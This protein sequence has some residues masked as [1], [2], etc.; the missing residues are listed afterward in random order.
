MA[1]AYCDAAVC[2]VDS[3]L[4]T[5][6]NPIPTETMNEKS[7][8]T[9]IGFKAN[10]FKF[11]KAV[12]L[13]P[14]PTGFVEVRGPNE[15][16]KSTILDAIDA[17]LRGRKSNPDEPIRHGA[18]RADVELDLGEY[19][20]RKRW[21]DPKNPGKNSLVVENGTGAAFSS[22]QGILDALYANTADP[23]AF[24][25]LSDAEKVKMVLPMVDLGID[26]AESA[27]SEKNSFDE[28]Q[29][30]NREVTSLTGAVAELEKKVGPVPLEATLS[31]G[32]L[33]K[34]L[35]SAIEQNA[36]KEKAQQ[37]YDNCIA[38]YAEQ[39]TTVAALEAKLADAKTELTRILA[40]GKLVRAELDAMPEPPSVEKV[41]TQIEAAETNQ[42]ATAAV[43]TLE[44]K[45]TE[46]AAKKAESEK[47]DAI[48]E[49]IRTARKDALAAAKF[50]VD[51]M[52]YDLENNRL[53]LKNIP[54][55]QAS[56]AERL[57]AATRLSMAGKPRIRVMFIRN[58]N[59]LD[60]KHKKI[61]LDLAVAEGWQVWIEIVDEKQDGPGIYIQE[62][63]ASG[64]MVVTEEVEV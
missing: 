42:A 8:L 47:L 43:A 34:M 18:D 33:S 45:R 15:N 59:L 63:V 26:L 64:D 57:T 16:G 60:S 53:T 39:V 20:I 51:G 22:P 48:I 2:G 11:L 4:I 44:E 54:I 3:D 17:A 32:A 30:V 35:E 55:S 46:L 40:E 29:L 50:P 13:R 41:R 37:K 56:T 12:Q 7:P 14:T 6:R 52:G 10:N 58:G 1:L 21:T 49:G 5:D 23:V 19:H 31:M 36:A 27:A 9:I 61:I 25:N 28:R 38:A 62:G 24:D